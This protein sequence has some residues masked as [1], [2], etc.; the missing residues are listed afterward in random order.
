MAKFDR[1]YVI[2]LNVAL[3][4][5]RTSKTVRAVRAIRDFVIRHAK[6]DEVIMGT[7]LNESV[8]KTGI[9]SPPKRVRVHI[10]KDDKT[11]IAYVDL[12]GVPIIIPSEEEKAAKEKE[13][14]EKKAAK[15]KEK[16]KE[17]KESPDAAK[18]EE[19]AAEVKTEDNKTTTNKA[20]E[21]PKS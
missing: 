14:E 7:S 21:E 19:P 3:K 20:E 18:K 17:E 10:L 11:N 8:W 6:A 12:P 9:A 13:K 15:E 5:P 2:P 4:A 16:N 1:E